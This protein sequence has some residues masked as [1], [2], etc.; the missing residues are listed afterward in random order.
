MSSLL[1]FAVAFIVCV[2]M[3]IG[4]RLVAGVIAGQRKLRDAV[5]FKDA[6]LRLA[7]GRA[8]GGSIGFYLGAALVIAATFMMVGRPDV[9]ETSMRVNVA[10]NGPAA[11][12]GI[13]RG[14][15]IVAV[16]GKPIRDWDQLRAEIA[17]R[18]G[19][20]TRVDI[21]RNGEPLTIDVVPERPLDSDKAKIMVGPFAGTKSVGVGEALGIGVVE[22]AK[23]VMSTVKSFVRAAAGSEKAELTGPVGIAKEVSQ[24]GSFVIGMRLGAA[25]AAYTWPAIILGLVIAALI[26]RKRTT[27]LAPT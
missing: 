10:T 19:L 25:L 8:L 1:G 16:E 2:A 3:L 18:E 21:D 14:D 5:T 26:G 17:V 6:S 12:A 22:P 7:L 20:T 9:D 15:R 11:R 4:G 13:K 27:I 23:I 24:L